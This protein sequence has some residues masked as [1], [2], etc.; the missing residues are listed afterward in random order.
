MYLLSIF[1]L[2]FFFSAQITQ[3]QNSE[4]YIS[5]GAVVVDQNSAAAETPKASI[6]ISAGATLYAAEN[7]SNAELIV[8]AETPDKNIPQKRTEQIAKKNTKKETKKQEYIA[9]TGTEIKINPASED[10]NFTHFQTT[11][12]NGVITTVSSFSKFIAGTFIEY[13]TDS[14]NFKH[15]NS[16]VFYQSIAFSDSYR[17]YIYVRPPPGNI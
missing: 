5:E 12:G 15:K 8:Q 7:I 10:R 13:T 16:K 9:K 3:I 2:P 17:F 14:N 11:A 4:I 6:Y 1:L